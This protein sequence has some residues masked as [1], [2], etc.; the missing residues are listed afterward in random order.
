MKTLASA[1][2]IALVAKT[3]L[4]MKTALVGT[5][6]HAIAKKNA[7]KIALAIKPKSVKRKIAVVVMTKLTT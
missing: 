6:V 7:V 1:S 4:A 2:K 5:I 3:A